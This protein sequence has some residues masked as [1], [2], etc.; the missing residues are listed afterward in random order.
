MM[1]NL[2]IM[3]FASLEARKGKETVTCVYYNMD[4]IV[5][6]GESSKKVKKS[7]KF[8]NTTYKVTAIGKMHLRS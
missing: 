5:P 4:I 6:Y 8:G 1:E 2:I 7:F 3:Y